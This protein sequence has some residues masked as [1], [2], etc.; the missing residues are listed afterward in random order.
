MVLESIRDSILSF[1]YPSVC[2]NCS[3]SLKGQHGLFCQGCAELLEMIS[4]EHRCPRCFS[5]QYNSLLKKCKECSHKTHYYTASAAVFEYMGPAASLIKQLK[6]GHKP[7]LAKGIGAFMVGQWANLSWPMPDVIVP[8][9]I[10]RSH[11]F[12]RGF[13][14]S[15]LI[16]Q[17]ISDILKVPALDVLG[18]K[19][20]DYSQAGLTHAQRDRLNGNSFYLKSRTALKDKTILLVDDVSTTGTTLNRCAEALLE[21]A[22]SAI[23]AL[24]FCG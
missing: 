21:G 1:L 11:W 7:Y 3:I 8:A 17:S 6:Y 24:T 22:P 9:P 14:Q 5:S 16:A 2:L 23:Y 15:L 19:S 13:N 12:E 4:P 10:S 20:G 18:R